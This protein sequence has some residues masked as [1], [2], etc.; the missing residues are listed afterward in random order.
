MNYPADT[1]L[2]ESGSNCREAMIV[3]PDKEA[4]VHRRTV[5]GSSKKP[6]PRSRTSY[7]RLRPGARRLWWKR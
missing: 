2:I 1:I 7:A 3:C 5:V 6:S 4:G